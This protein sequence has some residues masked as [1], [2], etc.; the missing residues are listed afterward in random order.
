MGMPGASAVY[1]RTGISTGMVPTRSVARYLM[2]ARFVL[3]ATMV[4]SPFWLAALFFSAPQLY[5]SGSSLICV[6]LLALVGIAA[7]AYFT[8]R[9][10]YFRQIMF[11][12]LTAHMAA[13]SIFLW[14]G[15][16]IY[17]GVADAFHY[18]TVGL[19]T[20]EDF[21]VLGW[22]AFHGPYWST[23]L[24]NSLCGLA[25]VFIGDALPTLFIAFAL[26]SLAGA[27]LFYRA[28]AIAFRDGDQK[29]FGFLVVLSPSILFWASSVGKDAL[30]QCFLALSCLGFARV[31]Q[32]R[33]PRGALLCAVG[34]LGTLLIRA[35]IAAMLAIAITFPYAVGR[36]R[37][38]GPSKAA[39]IV[40]IPLLM[41]G[42]YL[43]IRNAGSMIDLPNN[44]SANMMQEANAVT[45]NSQ[46]G[47]SSFN[48]G[49]SL[50][51]RIL[52]S[53]LLLVRPFPWEMHSVMSIASG[54]ESAGWILLCWLRRRQIWLT[55]RNWR[56]PYVGFLLA[57]VVIFV[58]A[59]GGAISNF[60]IL[61]RQRIMV[62]P[63]LLMLACARQKHTYWLKRRGAEFAPNSVPD[64]TV[65]AGS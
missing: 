55:L 6:P 46:V 36:S 13:S 9:D 21:E 50:P 65:I 16:V 10:S 3:T 22:G 39:R 54:V 8:Q 4:T 38:G 41:A 58:G 49:N 35:H 56:D 60:G 15:F 57:Y 5:P 11:A 61:S 37:P 20:A 43:V 29:L 31:I 28:F 63:F 33:S 51:V 40:L 14:I 32:A 23:N 26:I 45:R 34:V 52:E 12:G 17:G 47:G 24:I 2:V 25:T 30:I 48:Q 1:D 7:V 62:T 59:F 42:T 19:L 44:S 64:Q 27:Y 53:P 18:W